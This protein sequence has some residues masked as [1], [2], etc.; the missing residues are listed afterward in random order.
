MKKLDCSAGSEGAASEVEASS[1]DM[2]SVVV[3][4]LGVTGTKRCDI[5]VIEGDDYYE[6]IVTVSIE[7]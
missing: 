3:D 2:E 5:E 1:V 6:G 4:P 7:V